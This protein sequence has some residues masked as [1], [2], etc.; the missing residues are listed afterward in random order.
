MKKKYTITR[1]ITHEEFDKS[2]LILQDN[3]KLAAKD[4]YNYGISLTEVCSKYKIERRT[5]QNRFKKVGWTYMCLREGFVSR[6]L[7]KGFTMK[8]I[9]E[10]LGLC[11]NNRLNNLMWEKIRGD[12]RPSIR[13]KIL[14]RDNFRCVLCGSDAT[15]RK[16]HIDHII[17][18]SQG[19]DSKIKNLRV[20]CET[21]NI[22][23]NTDLKHNNV[24][25]AQLKEKDSHT[26]K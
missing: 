9:R 7:S 14:K 21:C 25:I 15:D 11:N 12:V 17:P 2:I 3:A 23:R 26:T 10:R 5:L 20:L 1:P 6:E 19:G 16:L 24:N 4:I 8:S 22:G 18:V 13:W